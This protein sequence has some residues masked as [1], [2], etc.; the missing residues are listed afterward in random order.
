M[1]VAPGWYDDGSGR[2]RWW[3]GTQWTEHV[4]QKPNIDQ[5]LAEHQPVAL[6]APQQHRRLNSK[7]RVPLLAAMVVGAF[8][9][10]SILGAAVASGGSSKSISL[11]RKIADQA[12]EL[13]HLRT[14]V[15]DDK[16]KK[17]QLAQEKAALDQRSAD[18]DKRESDIS[19]QEQAIE[20]NTI[21]GDGVFLVGKDIQ[22]GTYRNDG[23]NGC[24]WARLSGTSG[25]LGDILAN[26]N[27]VGQAVVTI[28]SSDVAFQTTRCGK[29][30]LVQ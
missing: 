5:S 13:D 11:E 28:A 27:V 15:A 2:D 21:P 7:R 23:S 30:T 1:S 22:P 24:Y 19:S 29:W 17:D 4:T 20:A 10:G 18:L 3:D 14:T 25:T 16:A 9:L 6:P 12:A 8:L 26:D